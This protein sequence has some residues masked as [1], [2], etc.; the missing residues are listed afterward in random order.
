MKT[1][2]LSI[3]IL[4]CIFFINI[5]SAQTVKKQQT[6]KERLTKKTRTESNIKSVD[7][8]KD[9][10]KDIISSQK[11]PEKLKQLELNKE[12]SKIKM[13]SPT[14]VIPNTTKRKDINLSNSKY[15]QQKIKPKQVKDE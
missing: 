12:F 13:I 3:T 14:T 10:K 7:V 8:S 4:F 1:L 6:N 15:K 11:N 2:N 5:S 9:E